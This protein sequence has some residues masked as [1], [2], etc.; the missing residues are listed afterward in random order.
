MVEERGLK[1]GDRP[2]K[3]TMHYRKIQ[4]IRWYGTLVFVAL[5]LSFIAFSAVA[6]AHA[7]EALPPT[8]EEQCAIDGGTWNGSSCDT[9][10][11][12]SSTSSGEVAPEQTDTDNTDFRNIGSSVTSENDGRPVVDASATSTEMEATEPEVSVATSTDGTGSKIG[13]TIF[14]GNSTAST[15]VE[16]ILNITKVNGFDSPGVTNST[17]ITSETDNLAELVTQDETLSQTGENNAQGGQGLATIITGNAVSTANIINMVNTNLFNSEGQVLLLAPSFGDGLDL[18]DFDLS[19]FF[20]EG[21]GN[22]PTQFGCTVLTCLNSSAL[23]ILNTNTATVTNSVLVR[24][25]TGA[26][27]ATSTNEVDEGG[28]YIETGNAYAAANVINM[29]NTN[30]IN[31]SYL[32]LSYNNFGDLSND[33][34]LPD[35]SF[36]QQL[37]ANG[38]SLPE[39]NASSYV[40]NNTNDENFF[41]TTT[42]NAITGENIATSSVEGA[43]EGHGEIFTGQAY[44]SANSFTS[45]NQTRVGGS[46]VFMVFRVWG[47]WSGTVL[48][49]PE[50][51]ETRQ[52]EYG[53]EIF[54]TGRTPRRGEAVGEYN[55]SNFLASSTN[56]A[57]VS[58]DVNVWAETGE[59]KAATE[60]ATSTIR[61]GDAYA[62]ANV[63]NLV[64]TNIVG[65]NWIFA[66]FN[67]FGDWGGDISFGGVG[68]PDLWIGAVAETTTPTL[69]LSDVIYHFTVKNNS[70]VDAENVLLE[71]KFDTN[72]LT[73]ATDGVN[74]VLRDTGV[75]WSLGRVA[76]RETR[77]VSYTAR[78]GG[79]PAGTSVSVPLTA[80]VSSGRPD[81]DNGDNTEEVTITVTAPAPAP[82]PAP[83]PEP[84]PEPIPVPAP[85]PPSGGGGSGGGGGGSSGGGGGSSGGGGGGSSG[86]GGGGGGGGGNPAPSGNAGSFAP[87]AGA[88]AGVGALVIFSGLNSGFSASTADPS[89]DPKVSVRKTPSLSASTTPTT[90]VVD[91]KVVVFNDKK[92][93]PAYHARLI[94]TLYD[95]SGT[96]VYTRSWDLE[97]LEPGDQVTLNYSVEFASSTKAGMYRNVARVTGQRNDTTYAPQILKMPSAEAWGDVQFTERGQ[98]LGVA[99]AVE[100]AA[101]AAFASCGPLLTSYLKQGPSNNATDVMKLQ[102]FL[103]TQGS[104]LPTTGLFGPMTS[105]AVKSFQLKYASEILA[106][107]GLK[108]PTGSVFGSTQRKINQLN[109]ALLAPAG[110]NAGGQ[111]GGTT[112]V[113][114]SGTS[115]PVIAG[116]PAIPVPAASPSSPKPPAPKKPKAP[117]KA[118]TPP[119]GGLGGWFKALFPLVTPQ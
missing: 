8:P 24:A 4:T 49:L 103:N 114:Q 108:A 57:T 50:G 79:V 72:M 82:A 88:S 47:N 91:Y 14:T 16:N 61:T 101:P 94:D 76:A 38:N 119:Q 90:T 95:P 68:R 2:E 5:M 34:V 42:A 75:L 32:V 1:E 102:T 84:E 104:K 110:A 100:A 117:A 55:S 56:M 113:I 15:T 20:N 67:I 48:G 81:A 46:S 106:P 9:T 52:T 43:H 74:A 58:T 99:T 35:A 53:L 116:A 89:V 37:F 13:G 64:N 28:V 107:L 66:T 39:L 22:S 6:V 40:V 93:R 112:A 12:T 83:V 118:Y 96:V 78:V 62:S 87:S 21:A 33:I 51:V 27:A 36:F 98:V 111:A 60:N 69:P 18:R 65:R 23:N 31:S 97:T 19:Y 59:N 7:Q 77:E 29:V 3:Y 80:T 86:G 41:G 73:F 92:A 25:V 44:S 115:T 71:A 10:S 109:C 45:A 54:S 11:S 30:F 70:D 85:P 63:L 105:A 17:I 26:N